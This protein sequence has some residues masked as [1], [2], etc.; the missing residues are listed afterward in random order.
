MYPRRLGFALRCAAVRCGTLR[1]PLV[2][3]MTIGMTMTKGEDTAVHELY[4]SSNYYQ[5]INTEYLLWSVSVSVVYQ[6]MADNLVLRGIY[7]P[8]TWYVLLRV[9]IA[10]GIL[11]FDPHIPLPTA[12]APARLTQLDNKG[13]L[14][15]NDDPVSGTI[16]SSYL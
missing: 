5:Y 2:L 14:L 15:N 1:T 16:M 6:V 3:T 10:P 8:G 12:A 9:L 4:R 13:G 11:F 7:I